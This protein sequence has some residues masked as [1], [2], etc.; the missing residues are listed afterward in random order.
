MKKNIFPNIP[1]KYLKLNSKNEMQSFSKFFLISV[2]LSIYLIS[3]NKDDYLSD[4]KAELKFSKDTVFFDTVFTGIGSATRYLTVKNPYDL[5]ILISQIQIAK[6]EESNFRL[7]IN[8]SPG[9]SAKD[10]EIAA[11]D[12]IF[13]FV[14]VNINPDNDDIIE[15]DQIVFTTNGNIQVVHLNAI[16]QDVHFLN[17][18]VINSQ[19]WT[20]EKPYL[21][22]NS[23]ALNENEILTVE[24]GTHIYSH[25]NSAIII[26]GTIKVNGT[27]EEPVIFE[28]DR[29]KGHSSVFFE[30]DSL[31]NYKDVPGQWE[32][33][34]L[35]KLSKENFFNFAVIKNAVTG[36]LVDSMQSVDPQLIIH[37][38][39]LEHHS[40]SGIYAQESSIFA[41]NCLFTNCGYH[42]L[43]LTR[44]GNYEF[45]H[46]TIGNYW[47]GPRTTASVYL[48]NYF[49]YDGIAY[50]YPLNKA[51]FGN[52]IIYGNKETEI[53]P[54]RHEAGD[55]FN[56]VFENCVLK[57]DPESSI[58]TG[59]INHFKNNYI[60]IDPY[61]ID[62]YDYNFNI[63]ETSSAINRAKLS[64]TNL[65]PSLLQ[66]DLNNNDRLNDE[67]PDIG[68]FEFQ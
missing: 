34:W 35:T 55:V 19:T 52:C 39:K 58:N 14:D 42:D 13:I 21:I 11:K 53:H 62:Y 32:G 59:D 56:Y 45:Y 8:G 5:P 36:I 15:Y 50:I 48:N 22:Y 23:V 16:G 18:S 49:L 68:T 66:F 57:I 40:F 30:N 54:D 9:N 44:G 63:D 24:G 31:D 29:L 3:C 43:A 64:I 38:S 60:N 12:S 17:D 20:N 25:R 61:F 46:C 10:V 67:N 1:F 26:L 51:Y 37:N 65:F 47:S 41:T 28:G 6:G 7:N 33:I 4:S 27:Y 2:F